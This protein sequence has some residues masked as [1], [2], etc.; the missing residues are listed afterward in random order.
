MKAL[1]T[2]WCDKSNGR[3]HEL[4]RLEF[5]NGEKRVLAQWLAQYVEGMAGHQRA[6]TASDIGDEVSS[7]LIHVTCPCGRTFFLD[8]AGPFHGRALTRGRRIEPTYD[9]GVSPD[10][11]KGQ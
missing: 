4:A 7:L 10:R 2:V 3:A 9:N 1:E 6:F 5:V 11:I 8:V